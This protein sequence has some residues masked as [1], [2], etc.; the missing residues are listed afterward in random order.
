M[1]RNVEDLVIGSG[2]LGAIVARRLAEG[3]RRVA[4]VE[5]GEAATQ[6]PGAHLRNTAGA[7]ADP[8]GFFPLVAEYQ[9]YYDDGAPEDGLPG[10]YSTSVVGG[11][12]I[13]WT[14]NCPR[15]VEGVDRP[16]E[17]SAGEWERCYGAAERYLEVRSDLFDD[18]YRGRALADRLER[19]LQPERR[20]VERLPL[21]G[22]RE[23]PQEIRYVDPAHVLAGGPP[24]EVIHG[25]A[26]TIELEGPRATGAAVD[27][28]LRSAANTVLATGAIETPALLWRSG[29]RP[30]AL[31]RFL[32]Y[33][34]VLI[35]QVVL[36]D[37]LWDPAN[38]DDPLPRL[39]IPPTAD[40]P[41]LTMVLRDTYPFPASAPDRDVPSS[42]VVE[43]Q[44][45]APMDPCQDNRLL[46][47]GDGDGDVSFQV[48]A[49]ASDR[50]RMLE[51][52]RDV[53]AVCALIG[54]F[55]EGCGPRWSPPGSEHLMGSC[56]MGM[57]SASS[58]TDTC[59]RVHGFENLYVAGNA[60]IP[61]RL[62]VNPTL[63]AAALA[64]RTADDILA[65]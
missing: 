45:F 61:T 39:A 33:H 12:G 7:R 37:G 9:H 41:W 53:D 1:T 50:E 47:S 6:P 46:V 20:A 22:A 62:A 11:S 5:R 43:M 17:L 56:R 24:V 42:R 64:V 3:G 14:N 16:D 59:G 10:A 29:I 30:P 40:R 34:P 36:E 13:L 19:A 57:D 25:E 15:A 54:R 31:G 63:T 38:S 8:D 55:R 49:G 51:I 21:S 27:G 35:A 23:G 18:S 28:S 4:I 44:V 26:R 60:V 52:E 32:S 48:P 58:V 2:L 65:C